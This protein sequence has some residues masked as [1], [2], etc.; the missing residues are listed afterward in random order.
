MNIEGKIKNHG[1]QLLFCDF[2]C[3]KEWLQHCLLLK[4]MNLI[5]QMSLK[6]FKYT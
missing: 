3:T 2:A 4:E 1:V 5:L 6:I